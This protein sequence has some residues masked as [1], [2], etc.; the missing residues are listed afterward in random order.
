MS[1][2]SRR[3][4]GDVMVYGIRSRIGSLRVSEGRVRKCPD[5]ATETTPIGL[6]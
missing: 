4:G 3:L 5:V 6:G 1:I 2:R